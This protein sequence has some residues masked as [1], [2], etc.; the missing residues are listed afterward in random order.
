[1][2]CII[3]GLLTDYTSSRICAGCYERITKVNR[4]DYIINLLVEAFPHVQ[5]A[6]L[7]RKIQTVLFP[8]KGK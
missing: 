6:R 3:C 7:S 5:D 1:M 8:N 2:I 4:L